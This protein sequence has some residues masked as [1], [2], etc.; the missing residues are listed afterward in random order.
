MVLSKTQAILGALILAIIALISPMSVQL[1]V[2]EGDES[3]TIYTLFWWTHS[4]LSVMREWRLNT[5]WTM[6]GYLP[7][8]ATRLVVPVQ[9]DRYYAGKT[10]RWMVLLAG[11]IGELPLLLI[12]FG[13]TLE[14]ILTQLVFPLPLHILVCIIVIFW[15]PVNYDLEPFP[16]ENA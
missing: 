8:V 7:F 6:L 15:K 10:S 12:V 16:L 1:G 14:S 5:F 3:Y 13:R 9:F 11:L 4:S 2:H